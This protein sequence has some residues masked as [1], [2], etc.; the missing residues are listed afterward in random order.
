MIG[1][2]GKIYFWGALFLGLG[3][4]WYAWK[5]HKSPSNLTAR[6]ILLASVIYL[7]LLFLFIIVDNVL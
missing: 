5:F 1:M 6:K 7:P 4:L 3:F 2:S